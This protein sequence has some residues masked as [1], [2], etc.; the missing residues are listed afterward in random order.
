VSGISIDQAF[1]GSCTNCRIEDIRIAASI[2]KDHRIADNVRLIVNP[3]SMKIYRQAM[4]EG[5][6]DIF[7]DAGAIIDGPTCGPCGGGGKGLLAAGERCISTTNR[8]FCGRMGSPLSEVYLASPAAVV[9]SAIQGCITDP[10]K[11]MEG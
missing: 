11:Y 2:L 7:L 8:N 6:F 10:R 3:A 5:L 4:K 9:A 1:L